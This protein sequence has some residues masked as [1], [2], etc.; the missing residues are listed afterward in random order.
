MEIPQKT[1]ART[2]TQSGDTAPGHLS[3]RM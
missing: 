2:G 3:K 1:R